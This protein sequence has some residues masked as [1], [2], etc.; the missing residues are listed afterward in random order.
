MK[1]HQVIIAGVFLCQPLFA[2][3]V[4]AFT[5]HPQTQ[6]QPVGANVTLSCTATGAD[7][8][9]WRHNGDDLLGET[10][11]TLS[12]T[13]AQT[14][15]SGYYVVIAKNATGWTP[16]KMAYLNVTG[17]GG[18][19]PFS[20][21][22]NTGGLSRVQ[23]QWFGPPSPYRYGFPV[24]NGIAQL[25]AGPEIDQLQSVPGALWDFTWYG[26]SEAGLFDCQRAVKTGQ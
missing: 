2:D 4:P 10:N 26:P 20:N 1:A 3:T 5:A 25:M 7:T 6:Q 13:S 19:V 16:S 23:Y 15:N 14:T 12:I 18:I 24:T 9:Q 17:G 22:D 21:Y 8:F 11:S